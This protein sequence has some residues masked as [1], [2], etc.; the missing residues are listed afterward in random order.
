MQGPV[1]ETGSY[2]PIGVINSDIVEAGCETIFQAP[3]TSRPIP[4]SILGD[5]KGLAILEAALGRDGR[6]FVFFQDKLG[7]E[8]SISGTEASPEVAF[9]VTV[10]EITKFDNFLKVGRYGFIEIQ[11][12]W[13]SMEATNMQCQIFATPIG[14]TR[15]HFPKL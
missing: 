12:P 2:V 7:G 9:D 1:G 3:L 13:T 14:F 6:A 10:A 5:R 15:W 11:T 4:I 8:I